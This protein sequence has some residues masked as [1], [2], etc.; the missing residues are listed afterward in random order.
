MLTWLIV[1]VLWVPV[2]AVSP[3]MPPVEKQV[4]TWVA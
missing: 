1:P 3:A 2:V 4:R